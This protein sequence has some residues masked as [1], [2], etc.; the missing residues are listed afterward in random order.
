MCP[1]GV[2]P[3]RGPELRVVTPG[4]AVPTLAGSEKGM[5]GFAD[6]QGAAARSKG[7][8]GLALDA[9]GSVLVADAGNH[10]VRPLLSTRSQS[11]GSCFAIDTPREIAI[12]TPREREREERAVF[13]KEGTG[14]RKMHAGTPNQPEHLCPSEHSISQS[15]MLPLGPP[16]RV[17]SQAVGEG[18]H[19]LGPQTRHLGLVLGISLDRARTY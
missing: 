3:I 8:R 6:G 14:K 1:R 7:P 16:E 18:G 19:E 10:A 17:Q 2:L 15:A 13:N 4:G 9:D 12:D 11:P 5:W